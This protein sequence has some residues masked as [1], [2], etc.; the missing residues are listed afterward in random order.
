MTAQNSGLLRVT[1]ILFASILMQTMP[2]AAADLPLPTPAPA[3]NWMGFYLGGSLGAAAG[4]STFSDPY[5]ASVFGDQ[6]RTTSLLAGLQLGYNWQVAP[7]WVV[8]I[9]GDASY[10]DN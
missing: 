4:M 8:G 2:L 10:L 7:R 1:V 5:G 9:Q 6:V 3:W